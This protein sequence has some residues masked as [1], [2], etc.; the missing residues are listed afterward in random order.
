VRRSSSKSPVPSP[1]NMK[2]NHFVSRLSAQQR[3]LLYVTVGIVGLA[4]LERFVYAPVGGRF[5][6]LDQELVVK[7]TQLRRN[8][9]SL[10][11]REGVLAAYSPYTAY[12]ST[13]A[14]DEETI[15]GLLKEIEELARK[16]GL[17]LLNV[18]PKPATKTD[19]G[20]QYPVE[21]ELETEMSPLIRFLHGLHGSK[22]LLRVNQ[23]R[24]DLKGGRGPQVKV[25]LLV[26]KSVI[27]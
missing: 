5:D 7:E 24:L 13:V 2:L 22:S 19:L 14:S 3:T 10:A 16:S 1:G 26:T 20:K 11:A 18:R 6:D 4:L 21:V 17:A 23:L 12:A 15:G 8:L 27:Q 25:S 9:K